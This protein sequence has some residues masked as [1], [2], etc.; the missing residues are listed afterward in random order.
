MEET[1]SVL[2]IFLMFIS[3]FIYMYLGK[4]IL[5]LINGAVL[6]GFLFSWYSV[7][8]NIGRSATL[9]WETIVWMALI[10]ILSIFLIISISLLVNRWFSLSKSFSVPSI[11]AILLILVVIFSFNLDIYEL[12]FATVI[13]LVPT[14]VIFSLLVGLFKY[15]YSSREDL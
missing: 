8:G 5:A 2:T 1:F 3:P 7:M 11:T 10:Y 12:I 6:I 14:Y 15:E 4:K 13:Y 9:N